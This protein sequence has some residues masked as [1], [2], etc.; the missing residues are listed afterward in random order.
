MKFNCTTD[1]PESI[2]TDCLIV[3]LYEPGKF[4]ATGSR[5]D[6]ASH[7]Y[8]SQILEYNDIQG[9]QSQ[10]LLVHEVP[11]IQ[12]AR[13]LLVG[14]GK[15]E[16]MSETRFRQVLAT[17]IKTLKTTA[18]TNAICC[19]TTL[20]IEYDLRWEIRQIIETTSDIYFNLGDFKTSDS[21]EQEQ[22]LTELILYAANP[23]D[24]DLAQTATQQADAIVKGVELT[25]HLS[26]LPGNICT[27]SY[28]AEQGIDLG[29][30]YKTIKTTVLN[31]VQMK[32]QG[33]DA[34]LSVSRGSRQEA[35]L[36]VMEHLHAADKE[37]KPI[38][39]VG[40]GITFD[41]GGNSLKSPSN[42]IDMHYDMCGAASVFGVMKAISELL[43]PL[44]V[45]GIVAAAEN[46]PG[47]E[48]TKPGDI[49][50]SLSG[51][52]IEVT[53]TDAEGRLVL[54]DALTYAE[55]FSPEYV[56][57]IATL[58]GAIIV[59]LGNDLNAL[60]CNDDEFAEQLLHAAKYAADYTWRMPLWDNYQDKLKSRLAD[61]TN[62]PANADRAAGSI[63]AANF[64]AR[65]TEQFKWAH[66]DVA[67]T[68]MPKDK[69]S[70]ATGRPVSLLTQF[71]IEQCQK[72][73]TL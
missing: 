26:N 73:K 45:I 16:P 12:A 54:C 23:I 22:A 51:K 32:K 8:L 9:K 14:L 10:T 61:F 44:N 71:L 53:N 52:T 34:L 48:A 27:P 6:K 1:K 5:L 64:L 58:T 3:G 42:M 46:M 59:A 2:K 38:V 28:L 20:P 67:G 47:G 62:S 72:S 24:A 4:G 63:V 18:A 21:T 33:M 50:K 57:D 68:A 65:F 29:R 55:R 30:Q 56:I 41:T 13:V 37:Q 69:S 39:L 66:L 17:A 43:L 35:R 11:N 7:G 36:I 25:K 15:E 60:F 40:K 70:G 19:L 31:E 49:I